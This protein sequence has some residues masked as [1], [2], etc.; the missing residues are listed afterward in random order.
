MHLTLTK[1]KSVKQE[2]GKIK[3][4]PRDPLDHLRHVQLQNHLGIQ[5]RSSNIPATLT[6]EITRS[7]RM[8]I[9]LTT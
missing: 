2:Q 8:Q 5:P 6:Q 9:S 1:I 4:A 3:R 7:N